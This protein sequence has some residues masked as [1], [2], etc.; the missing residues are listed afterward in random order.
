MSEA[1]L[2][3]PAHLRGRLA[4]A[5]ES[6]LLE[7]SS[8]PATI[9]A[10]LGTWTGAEEAIRALEEHARLGLSAAA[11]S[12]WIRSI[13]SASARAPATDLVW[14]GPE[15]SGVHARDTRRVYEELLGSAE[16]SV[17]ASTYAFFDGPRAFEVLA[18]RME[19]APAL[20]VVLFLNIQRR[21]GETS[22]EEELVHRFADRFWKSDWP[23][24][25]RPVVYY[26]PRSVEPGGP[27]GVLHAK[28]VVA[29]T[30][31][32]FVTSA[33]LT[34]AALDRNIELGLLV[35]DEALALSVVSHFQALIDAS[36]VT[37]LPMA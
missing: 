21:R 31:V 23:G 8:T 35:R 1:L 29:D 14:S 15:V 28:A 37:Q 7:P 19:E 16:Q 27:V 34:D 17:W 36:L 3:L 20:R 4:D 24:S 33:N 26:D 18:R 11:S 32:V 22:G 12:A 30:K 13:D 5:L 10:V 6:G 25:R 9:R 2:G